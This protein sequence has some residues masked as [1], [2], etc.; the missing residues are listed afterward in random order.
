VV[1]GWHDGDMFNNVLKAKVDGLCSELAVLM[2]LEPA[3]SH[4]M[5]TQFQMQDQSGERGDTEVSL[6]VPATGGSRSG[7]WGTNLG[8]ASATGSQNDIRYAY[9]P[10]SRR[11]AVGIG[12]QVTIYDTED[13]A[14]SGVS[15]QT[16]K[17]PLTMK[18]RYAVSSSNGT[19]HGAAMT[20]RRCS[21]RIRKMRT[22]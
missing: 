11:L 14:I 8:A 2:S 15:Q 16:L 22:R 7:W 12:D 17:A 10:D 13:H 1:P 18:Q 6:F 4:R 5:D 21:R 3:S 19:P 20:R 9:F